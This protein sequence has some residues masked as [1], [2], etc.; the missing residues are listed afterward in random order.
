MG[1]IIKS[2]YLSESFMYGPTAWDRLIPIIL[3]GAFVINEKKVRVKSLIHGED[4]KDTRFYKKYLTPE[5]R[6]K[7]K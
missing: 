2:K 7:V 1:E 3:P 4:N 5:G 6:D